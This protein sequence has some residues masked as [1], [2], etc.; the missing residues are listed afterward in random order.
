MSP[1]HSGASRDDSLLQP[2]LLT[3]E[4]AMPRIL[5]ES[6]P[7]LVDRIRKPASPQQ[8]PKLR[9]K[10]MNKSK[11]RSKGLA[12]G[13]LCWSAHDISLVPATLAADPVAAAAPAIVSDAVSQPAQPLLPMHRP[14][15]PTSLEDS[16]SDSSGDS[17]DLAEPLGP[18]CHPTC[19]SPSSTMSVTGVAVMAHA[20]VQT[21]AIATRN[22]GKY[23]TVIGN[24]A[25]IC[26]PSQMAST[27]APTTGTR[28]TRTQMAT[29]PLSPQR[30]QF[31]QPQQ[32]SPPPP[33]QEPATSHEGSE[34]STLPGTVALDTAMSSRAAVLEN[35]TSNCSSI[36]ASVQSTTG[37]DAT[38]PA[39]T[40]TGAPIHYNNGE[41]ASLNL[42]PPKERCSNNNASEKPAV[43]GIPRHQTDKRCVDSIASPL[44]LSQP[45]A[46]LA[47]AS[48]VEQ[49]LFMP[50]TPPMKPT[51]SEPAL[52]V[53]SNLT[54]TSAKD[55]RPPKKTPA[56]TSLVNSAWSTLLPGVAPM[57]TASPVST[58]TNSPTATAPA[59]TTLPSTRP[60]APHRSGQG[61]RGGG[62]RAR[63][64]PE[65]RL[66]EFL[67]IVLPP[68]QD[69]R[70]TMEMTELFESVLPT[71]QSHD[72]RIRLIQKIEQI[73]E[74]EWPGRD[75]QAKPFGSTVNELGTRTSDVDIC[76]FTTWSGL[77]GVQM[78]AD[79]FQKHGMQ[80]IFC[81]PQ[82]KVPIVKFWDPELHLS[83]DLNIN[84]RLGMVNTRLVKTYVGIDA[85][86]RPF[87]MVIKHWARKRVLNDAANGGTIS[88]YTWICIA[89][90]FL[91][92]RSPPILPS[93]HDMEH[94]L[95][96][97][98]E[99][100]N[101]NNTSFCEDL[102]RMEGFGLANKES[103]GGLLYAFF[104]RYAVEFDYDNQVISL[105]HGCYLTKETKGWN[106]PGK[107]YRLL[108]VEEPIDTSRNLGNSLDLASCKGL[109][110]EFRRALDILYH[111]GNLDQCCEQW[112]F[113]PCYYH[114]NQVH[115]DNQMAGK[116]LTN[117]QGQHRMSAYG[118]GGQH[119]GQ[120]G[121]SHFNINGTGRRY[122][123]NY[124]SPVYRYEDGD[125]DDDDD[126]VN[127]S[128]IL[129]QSMSGGSAEEEDETAGN[130]DDEQYGTARRTTMTN[131]N[132]SHNGHGNNSVSF[133][134]EQK[135][136]RTTRSG[137]F[138]NGSLSSR[139]PSSTTSGQGTGHG[140]QNG[141][142]RRGSAF[143]KSEKST[144]NSNGG[145]MTTLSSTLTN[146]S[147]TPRKTRSHSICGQNGHSLQST[148]K[149]GG[150]GG[151][152]QGTTPVS[153]LGNGIAGLV[154][155]M[156]FHGDGSHM[157]AEVGQGMNGTGLRMTS[158]SRSR[159]DSNRAHGYSH[160]SGFGRGVVSAG[161]PLTYQDGQFKVVMGPAPLMMANETGTDGQRRS[162]SCGGTENKLSLP[163]SGGRKNSRS[164]SGSA[165]TGD[166][167]HNG[168]KAFKATVEFNLA[169]I[170][171][172]AA[173][174]AQAQTQAV[175]ARSREQSGGTM[176]RSGNEQ[177][178]NHGHSNTQGVYSLS[179][180][181]MHSPPRGSGQGLHPKRSSN[182]VNQVSGGNN[183]SLTATRSAN[184][185]AN[186]DE[187]VSVRTYD[188]TIAHV[189]DDQHDNQGS[190]KR[191]GNSKRNILWSTNSNRGGSR[192]GPHQQQQNQPAQ[193][194][195]Q[196]Q[197][198][199]PQLQPQQK[200][201]RQQQ[202]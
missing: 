69:M 36:T 113:P 136:L 66:H 10:D 40:P 71:E 183:P 163:H 93:L 137:S 134:Q 91:Q 126:D 45:I 158:R 58:T 109:K 175:L 145:S 43:E 34:S 103:L 42:S 187:G 76:I 94:I 74:K 128:G 124:R 92:M 54:N 176:G 156:F 112:V 122:A 22:C 107:H 177:R 60:T 28:V 20:A 165:Y 198:P 16:Q 99:V 98:N 101:G 104:R 166:G 62:N 169:E 96:D 14:D 135:K 87:A 194:Q 5:D 157:E 130:A 121:Q 95:A 53:A 30:T 197:E 182:G 108:C 105:R 149:T 25:A 44:P 140:N 88:T 68:E 29:P 11:S 52:P 84:T 50:L 85:R 138:Q 72:R 7:P 161:P 167:D 39:T 1:V 148:L 129:E 173:A 117:G 77:T 184:G 86:V 168:S 33:P 132:G 120:Q 24:S 202:Q 106:I 193:Q 49:T 181:S 15:S 102:S 83:C 151:S 80:K 59:V 159:Q 6:T 142:R 73:L 127:D 61:G 57:R 201:N 110:L 133:T 70:L 160:G 125:D 199:Q 46:A 13:G 3:A 123:T 196:P 47:A 152:A 27:P 179:D 185:E 162:K 31:G 139:S 190:K 23:E 189:G 155:D 81:V 56:S 114:N 170:T 35:A 37:V 186:P 100:I 171:S 41:I 153:M 141:A 178:R 18:E 90:N 164:G 195:Q 48:A 143:S 79:A 147:T 2:S 174:R 67:P 32:P 12:H 116:G 111:R 63:I 115:Y 131:K 21:E 154:P 146:P 51:A 192:N 55:A 75:I 172:A 4:T 19:V 191:G 89:L 64:S 26:C 118:A 97:D 17:V 78:L 188:V 82:A 38:V 8:R 200:K 144:L 150:K 180:V 119:Y 65:Q 9:L